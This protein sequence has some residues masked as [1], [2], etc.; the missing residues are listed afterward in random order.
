MEEGGVKNQKKSLHRL[1]MAPMKRATIIIYA[2][3]YI[4]SFM[5]TMVHHDHPGR[6]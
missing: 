2:L 6:N 4:G 5:G 1:W 3:D